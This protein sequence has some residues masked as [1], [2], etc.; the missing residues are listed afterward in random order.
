MRNSGSVR[1]LVLIVMVLFMPSVISAQ[2]DPVDR[3]ISVSC[4]PGFSSNGPTSYSVTTNFSLNI[5]G[6]LNRRVHGCEIG[7]LF[8]IEKEDVIGFQAAGVGSFLGTDLIGAQIAGVTNVVG[9]YASGFQAAGVGNFVGSDFAGFQ[10]AGV[11][12]VVGGDFD[13]V[14]FAGVANLALGEVRGVQIAGPFNFAEGNRGVQIAVV[15]ICGEVTGGQIGVVNI[16]R[17]VTGFQ[18]A[19]VNVA[20]E[21]TGAPLGLVSIVGNGQFHV[22]AWV[23]ETSI[24][25]VGIKCGAKHIYT[26]L[27]YGINPLGDYANNKLGL[28]IGGHIPADPLFVDIDAVG[29]NVVEGLLPVTETGSSLLARLRVTGGWQITP[30]VAVTL[31]PTLNVWHSTQWDGEDIPIIGLPLYSHERDVSGPWSNI[32]LGFNVGVQLL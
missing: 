28:G 29:Y 22:N 1:I 3:P 19:V 18:L 24:L 9:G 5:L 2:A 23:D 8:N 7:G 10:G 17:K 13:V 27:E 21:M 32:W 25:N 20:E 11:F 15:N 6:G 4:V 14:Q 26:V 31:G 12:N 16:A 30:K